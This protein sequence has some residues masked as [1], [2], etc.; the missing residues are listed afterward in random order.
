MAP[1]HER[2][3]YQQMEACRWRWRAAPVRLDVGL[4]FLVERRET[5]ESFSD[6]EK[7]LVDS[8]PRK[9]VLVD[10]NSRVSPVLPDGSR[11]QLLSALGRFDRD[12][13]FRDPACRARVL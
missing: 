11:A 1:L 9:P 12:S 13:H 10:A 4:I 3:S 7:E 8:C 6:S 5:P 2:P